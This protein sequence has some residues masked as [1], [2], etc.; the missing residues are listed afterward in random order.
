MCGAVPYAEDAEDPFEIY[1]EIMNNDVKFPSWMKDKKGRKF[2]EQLLSK[3]PELRLGGSYA[4]LKAHP[5]FDNFDWDKL[6]NKELE[7]PFIIPDDK[8][9]SAREIKA[10]YSNKVPVTEEIK[11]EQAQQ[12]KNYKKEHARDPNWDKDF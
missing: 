6:F 5:W 2:I 9:I 8:L 11:I 4:A 10:Q 3:V 12:K 7:K 1:E